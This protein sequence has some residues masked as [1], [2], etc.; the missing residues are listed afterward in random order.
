MTKP[1]NEATIF[2]GQVINRKELEKHSFPVGSKFHFKNAS[3]NDT[4]TVISVRKDPGAE[5][6]QILGSIAGEVW[7]LLS[8]LQKEAV[9]GTVTFPAEVVNA[10]AVKPAK[11]TKSVK[12]KASKKKSK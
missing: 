1:P 4:F 10:K 6:R 7:M 8:S 3:Y 5:Y 2:H 11:K 12:K 9:V